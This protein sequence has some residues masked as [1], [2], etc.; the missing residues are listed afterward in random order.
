MNDKEML[1]KKLLGV[2]DGMN[3]EFEEIMGYHWSLSWRDDSDI[4]TVERRPST[5]FGLECFYPVTK[6]EGLE[7]LAF[8]EAYCEGLRV[9]VKSMAGAPERAAALYTKEY[10]REIEEE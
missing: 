9:G 7:V 6:A 10:A 2:V 3:K 4:F 5:A 8:L 1:L